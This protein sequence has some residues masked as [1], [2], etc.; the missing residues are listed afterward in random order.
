MK[1]GMR[2]NW[3]I[4]VDRDDTRVLS[5]NYSRTVAR[6]R[7]QFGVASTLAGGKKKREVKR[8]QQGGRVLKGLWGA[9]ERSNR[10]LV[11]L[12]FSDSQIRILQPQDSLE[13][14][15]LFNV[16]AN[17]SWLHGGIAGD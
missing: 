7:I 15:D 10:G 14:P 8:E 12:D 5:R 3:P 2:D 6:G 16:H 4:I 1:R 11:S 17:A 9:D 13:L